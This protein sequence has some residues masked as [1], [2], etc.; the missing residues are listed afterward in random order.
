MNITLKNTV[1][2]MGVAAMALTTM[3][4]SSAEAGKKRHFKFGWGYHHKPYFKVYRKHYYYGHGCYWL[5]KK[6]YRTGKRYWLNRYYD[7][8]YHY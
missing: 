4:I 1:M 3:Q 5:K 6:Y 7:C 2:A 8:K